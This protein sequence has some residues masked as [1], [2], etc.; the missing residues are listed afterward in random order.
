MSR[1]NEGKLSQIKQATTS[2][3]RF[4]DETGPSTAPSAPVTPSTPGTDTT[5]VITGSSDDLYTDAFNFASQRFFH[6][7]PWPA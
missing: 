5:K 7:H 6:A 2:E 4:A 1:S 3:F